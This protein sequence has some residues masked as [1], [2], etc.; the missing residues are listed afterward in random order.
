MTTANMADGTRGRNIKVCP[1]E[2]VCRGFV[3]GSTA[4]L[5]REVGVRG[6]AQRGAFKEFTNETEKSN[7]CL[8][9]NRRDE[10]WAAS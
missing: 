6:Q 8:Q 5:L 10:V 3:T 9:L 1:V 7:H 2:L 4:Q